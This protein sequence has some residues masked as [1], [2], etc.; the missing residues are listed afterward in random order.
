MCGGGLGAT[1]HPFFASVPN[2]HRRTRRLLGGKLGKMARGIRLLY[3]YVI[4]NIS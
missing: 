4:L 2:V 1:S 3:L